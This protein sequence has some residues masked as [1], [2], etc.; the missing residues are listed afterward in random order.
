MPEAPRPK[1]DLILGIERDPLERMLEVIRDSYPKADAANFFLEQKTG[2][3]NIAGVT[4]LRDVLSHLAT[5][6]DPS[7]TPE[8]RD[9]QIVN[10]KE[11]I[12][13]SIVEPYEVTY[14]AKMKELKTC[15]E[16]YKKLVLP[17]VDNHPALQTAP[18]RAVVDAKLRAIHAL[19]I[20]GRGGKANN[21]WNVS[22][23]ESVGCYVEAVNLTTD[24]HD[25][26]NQ[27]VCTYVQW[28][29]QR[30]LTRLHKK[31]YG[32]AIV[33][34]L[35]AIIVWGIDHREFLK[36]EWRASVGYVHSGH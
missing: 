29:Q 2:V 18:T 10:A 25:S 36:T 19:A 33:G 13:R 26:L 34:L 17:N 27:C 7:L 31:A 21:D 11:H 35:F 14:L 32:L 24:L 4:N 15:F 23:D 30:H 8:K 9:E 16:Q 3:T 22:W 5:L 6:L 12:R 20:K 28:D 1:K